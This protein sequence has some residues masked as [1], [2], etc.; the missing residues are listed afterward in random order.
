MW[1]FLGLGISAIHWFM[2]APQPGERTRKRKWAT[3]NELQT[4]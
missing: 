4:F 2:A 3:N 1:I